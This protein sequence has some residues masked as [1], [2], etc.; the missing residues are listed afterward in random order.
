MD[1]LD[2]GVGGGGGG[3]GS[4]GEQEGALGGGGE[5]L[6]E[7]GAAEL[8]VV[9]DH[10]GADL[11]EPVVEHGPAGP[12]VRG[13]PD[14]GEQLVEEFGRGAVVSGEP[15]DSVGREVGAVGGDGVEEGGAARAAWGR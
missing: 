10:D 4:G 15:D 8:Q 6:V 14:G 9:D 5:E 2:G 11:A 7:G 12:V 3:V 1:V 13:V